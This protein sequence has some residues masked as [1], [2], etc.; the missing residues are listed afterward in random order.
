MGLG[1]DRTGD[2]HQFGRKVTRLQA[3]EH[4]LVARGMGVLCTRLR[5]ELRAGVPRA[6][7]CKFDAQT[8][9]GEPNASAGPQPAVAQV[10]NMVNG[11]SPK[12]QFS[13][14]E[15]RG[16]ATARQSRSPPAPRP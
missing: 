14:N 3:G 11:C 10:I 13:R 7:V 9:R 12:S 5:T 2:F 6:Y 15:T 1:F 8:R 16:A 4:H